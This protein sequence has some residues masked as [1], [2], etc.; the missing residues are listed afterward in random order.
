M[1]KED[2]EIAIKREPTQSEGDQWELC[3]H[4]SMGPDLPS[5]ESYVPLGGHHGRRCIGCGR[6]I[7]DYRTIGGEL[8][9]CR[10]C[11]AVADHKAALATL[12]E[13]ISR[14]ESAAADWKAHVARLHRHLTA[15]DERIEAALELIAA[16]GCDC[17]CGHHYEEHA[18]DCDRCLACRID[19]ALTARTP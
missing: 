10:T 18:D 9:P 17:E 12:K 14:E 6:W 4:Q 13:R 15:A 5:G 16:N 11:A 7:W 3:H 1:R 2:Y 19:A 8:P